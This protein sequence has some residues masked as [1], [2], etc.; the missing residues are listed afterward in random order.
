MQ[1]GSWR[2]GL[3][4]FEIPGPDRHCMIVGDCDGR[5][6]KLA[7]QVQVFRVHIFRQCRYNEVCTFRELSINTTNQEVKSTAVMLV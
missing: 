6:G 4:G 2:G 1:C 5:G 7:V 3:P